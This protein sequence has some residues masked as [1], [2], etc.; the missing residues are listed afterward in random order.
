MDK[1]LIV[2]FPS[3][4]KRII[5][6][7]MEGLTGLQ[8]IDAWDL[9]YEGMTNDPFVKGNYPHQEGVWGWQDMA[10]QVVL[11]VHNIKLAMIEYH[12]QRMKLHYSTN[13][14]ETSVYREDLYEDA[15]KRFPDFEAWCNIKMLGEIKQ[16]G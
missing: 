2:G 4:D 16:Y 8:T 15:K 11:A 5:Y 12:A 7:Q 3:G 10:D 13:Y 14:D 1:T 9:D 6:T